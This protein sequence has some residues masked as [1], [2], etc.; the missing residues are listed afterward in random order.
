MDHS[1]TLRLFN[2]IQVDVK[3]SKPI[4]KSV[5]H[6]TIKN[7]YVLQPEID[8]TDSMLTEIENIIGI[9]GVKANATFHK[10]WK[11]I[12]DASE[13]TLVTQQILH[14]MT[15]YGFEALGIYNKDTVYIP[16]EELKLPKIKTN[17]P[18]TVVKS[19]SPLELLEKIVMLGS[20]GIALSQQTLDDI[21]VIIERNKYDC[22]FIELIKNRELKALILDFYQIIPTDPTEF[23]RYLISKLTEESLLIKNSYLIEKIKASNGKFLDTMLKDAPLGLGTIFLRYRSLFLAMK[24]ISKNK[25]F[26]NRLRKDAKTMHIPLPEDYLNNVTSHIKKGTFTQK[27]LKTH[28]KDATVFRKVRLANALSYRLQECSSIIYRVRNGRGWATDFDWNTPKFT[29]ITQKAL[30]NVIKSIAKDISKNVKGKKFYIPDNMHYALPATEKQFTGNFPTG[31]YI[32]VPKDLIVGVHWYNQENKRVDLDLSVISKSGKIGWNSA[33][34]STNNEVL[35]SGDITDAPKPNGATELFYLKK[36]IEEPHVLMLNDYTFGENDDPVDCKIVVARDTPKKFDKNYM[37]DINKII[38]NTTIKLPTKQSILGLVNNVNGENRVYF[39]N[40]NIGNSIVSG[41][42][43]QA[44]QSREYLVNSTISCIDL[45]DILVEAGASILHSTDDEEE[46][47]D[48][49]P[50]VVTKETFINLLSA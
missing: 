13:R 20:S 37:L 23:L 40:I 30:N 32:T 14:Y 34:K 5:A 24:S 44:D 12:Q 7:G 17:I 31:S 48:L 21:M 2:A 33:H 1:A 26:F 42:N 6:R 10:S 47:I 27:A 16:N 41:N 22:I 39:A 50:E 11:T 46:Y 25:A 36:G 38:V 35:F 18:L 3:K 28:L 43:E 19:I 8:P 29:K 45:K 4:T 9:S 15:T 49:S